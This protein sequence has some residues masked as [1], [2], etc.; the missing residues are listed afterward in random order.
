MQENS[1]KAIDLAIC[2]LFVM[3]MVCKE[4]DEL[5]NNVAY[6]HGRCNRW[7]QL[8]YFPRTIKPR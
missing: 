8:T 5:I 1:K 2:I 3:I 6:S 7:E 4:I